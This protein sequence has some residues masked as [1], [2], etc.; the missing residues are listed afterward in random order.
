MTAA[1]IAVIGLGKLG[2]PLAAV[3]AAEGG[4]QVAGADLNPAFVRAINEGRAPIP[5]PALQELIDRAGARLTATTD[6]AAAVREA[7]ATFVIVPTPS[8]KD[9]EFLN[10]H[11]LAAVETIGGALHGR[12]Q[13]HL[14]VIT[15]TVM[16]GATDG[17][18]RDALERR[19]G[20][21]VGAGVGL[22]YNPEFV[23]LGAV[24]RGITRP[25]FVLIG[26]SD[27]RAGDALAAIHARIAPGAPIA[28]MNCVNAEI[29][30]LAVNTFVTTKIS[31][32]NMLA[33]LCE[34]L[35]G[36]D[37]DT[38][39]AAIG[40]D[41]RIGGKYLKGAIGY[42]GPCFPR[43]NLAF[44]ALARRLGVRADLA[45]A[46]DA[47][48]R[49][50]VDRLVALVSR[51][52]GPGGTV[53]V[54]GQSYKPDTGVIEESQ[55]VMLADRLA[56]GGH[57]VSVWDPQATAAVAAVLR[58]RVVAAPSAVACVE[59]ADVVVIATPWPEFARLPPDAFARRDRR[60]AV[61]DCWRM[62]PPAPFDALVDLVY[63]GRADTTDRAPA[64]GALREAQRRA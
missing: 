21:R 31:Y 37:V 48:N 47:M 63:P 22:C 19:S 20:R 45:L 3:L 36:A 35:P 58:E 54:L 46:T 23:A 55:G 24:V 15:S 61:V 2:A 50:Q 5:E 62:L 7:S 11:V 52:A 39:T 29:A 26:E 40:R 43:D 8:G 10:D 33:G 17:A 51:L 30:K 6:V 14:V 57:R 56:G 44:A 38:V 1:R 18:I 16:P 28:R 13:D 32:A 34:R 12:L 27:S 49:H 60:I 41:D 53:A 59:G 42:G 25:D 64:P 4:Y 9:E